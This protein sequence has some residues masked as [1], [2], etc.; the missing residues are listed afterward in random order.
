MLSGAGLWCKIG[1]VEVDEQVGGEGKRCAGIGRREGEV[2]AQ[3]LGE[4]AGDIEVEI[5]V[6]SEVDGRLGWGEAEF[7]G[8]ASSAAVLAW[9]VGGAEEDGR[10]GAFADE[11]GEAGEHGAEELE[12]EV[13]GI[14]EIGREEE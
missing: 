10:V 9:C 3:G 6:A 4:L 11:P 13:C 2:A 8:E 1:I 7:D 12:V 14:W 5:G